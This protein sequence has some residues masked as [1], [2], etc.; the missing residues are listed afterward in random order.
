MKEYEFEFARY[1]DITDLAFE[2]NPD[3]KKEWYVKFFI[4]N[5]VNT[6]WFVRI[7][8]NINEDYE[9]KEWTYL[10]ERNNID[11]RRK[12]D[13]LDLNKVKKIIEDDNWESWDIIECSSLE[14]AIDTLLTF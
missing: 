12:S 7:L 11:K 10:I 9:T 6:I 3:Y 14:E 1:T 8:E 5:D 4:C 13:E 2:V